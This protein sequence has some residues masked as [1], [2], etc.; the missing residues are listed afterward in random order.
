MAGFEID[1]TGG[2]VRRASRNSGPNPYME[3]VIRAAEN[4]EL[5]MAS[6]FANREEAMAMRSRLL[7]AGRELGV[8]VLV[9][10]TP[11]AKALKESD[12]NGTLRFAVTD[13]IT[14]TRKPKDETADA[15]A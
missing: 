3:D 10:L 8:S 12:S 4:R 13:K 11:S 14:R 6:R 2:P 5:V 15:A 7:D 9:E 1:T